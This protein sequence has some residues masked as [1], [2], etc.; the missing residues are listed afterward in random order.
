MYVLHN[1]CICFNNYVLYIHLFTQIP[2]RAI[3]VH[4][5]GGILNHFS[6][7]DCWIEQNYEII[8]NSTV[9]YFKTYRGR[10][11]TIALHTLTAANIC[12][13][14]NGHHI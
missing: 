14:C 2:S 8:Q 10:D 6:K 5:K 12:K 3:E 9:Y 7:I 11:Q 4:V 1:F 13:Y